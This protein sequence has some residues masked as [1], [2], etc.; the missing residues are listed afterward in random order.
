[1]FRKT[2]L[3]LLA[4]SLSGL[5]LAGCT[6]DN[7]PAYGRAEKYDR[8]HLQFG[9]ATLEGNT[10][11]EPV[12][13]VRDQFGLM[14]ITVTIRSTTN[15]DQYVDGF[16]TYLRDGQVVEKTGPKQIMLKANLPDTIQFDS[17]Q[18]ADDYFVSL[19]YSK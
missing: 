17:T 2:N 14:H 11:V 9:D 8:T 5:L 3:A 6:Q 16:V 7:A 13:A 1:M 10:R 15:L 4:L 18:P 19:T 12:Q